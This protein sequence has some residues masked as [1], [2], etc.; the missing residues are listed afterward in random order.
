MTDD[1][2]IGIYTSKTLNREKCVMCGGVADWEV[3]N[4]GKENYT[5]GYCNKCT[6]GEMK[7]QTQTEYYKVGDYNDGAPATT[8]TWS[9]LVP[10]LAEE[11]VDWFLEIVRPML[12]SYFEHGYKH[13][14]ESKDE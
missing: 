9:D 2:D 5:N 14:K 3:V 10:S 1:M 6:G 8:S 12:I 7:E 13:G 4:R 11:H